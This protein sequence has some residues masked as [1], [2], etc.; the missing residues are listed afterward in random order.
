M[1]MIC[2]ECFAVSMKVHKDKHGTPLKASSAPL[3]VHLSGCSLSAS[4]RSAHATEL[5][6]HLTSKQYHCNEYAAGELRSVHAMQETAR[7][8]SV[9]CIVP[10]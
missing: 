2:Q 8:H 10:A 1:T 9:C 3:T 6:N 7:M 5:S 4:F